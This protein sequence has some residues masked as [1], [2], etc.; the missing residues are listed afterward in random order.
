MIQSILILKRSGETIFAKH[1]VDTDVDDMIMTGLMSAL[2]TFTRH[3]LHGTIQ[4]IEI[5]PSR[6][7]FETLE[8]YILIACI[9]DIGDS[10]IKIKQKLKALKKHLAK[11]YRDRLFNPVVIL[12]DFRRLDPEIEEI[13]SEGTDRKLSKDLK[14]ELSKILQ[15]FKASGG[16]D[17]CALV[18]L[19]GDFMLGDLREELM[20]LTI[21]QVDAFWKSRSEML[22]QII[23]LHQ[24]KYVIMQKINSS[25]ILSAEIKEETEI[26]M[27]TFL[28]EEVSRKIRRSFQRHE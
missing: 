14:T 2:F 28:I 3:A 7:L 9:F 22:D 1:F 16:L 25:V 27:A 15:D 8:D 4:D 21:K 26:G 12:D 24:N 11:N 18:F 6:I 17:S 5:G 23:L 10:I 19:T 20:E 13:I